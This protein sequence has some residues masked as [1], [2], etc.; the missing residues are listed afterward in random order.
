[1]ADA[2]VRLIPSGRVVF[3][4]PQEAAEQYLAD[5]YPRVH[6]EPGVDYG[7]DGPQ[8]DAE[9]VSAPSDDK[10]S[11]STGKSSTGKDAF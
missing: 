9:V 6:V 8:P 2:Q 5:H 4:G 10:T 1:M 11:K 7:D 3:R